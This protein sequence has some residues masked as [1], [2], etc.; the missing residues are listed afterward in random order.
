M[1]MDAVTEAEALFERSR[2]KDISTI[3][4]EYLALIK[5]HSL[6]PLLKNERQVEYFAATVHF[7]I[8]RRIPWDAHTTESFQDLFKKPGDPSLLDLARPWPLSKHYADTVWVISHPDVLS[9]AMKR[10]V[11]PPVLHRGTTLQWMCREMIPAQVMLLCGKSGGGKTLLAVSLALG[12]GRSMDRFT[13]PDGLKADAL[14][15]YCRA[16]D[17]FTGEPPSDENKRSDWALGCIV[18]Y[19]RSLVPAANRVRPLSCPGKPPIVL[20][21]DEAGGYVAAVRGLCDAL[22]RICERLTTDFFDGCPVYLVAVGTGSEGAPPASGSMPD[23]CRVV[24]VDAPVWADLEAEL[25]QQGYGPAV[26]ALREPHPTMRLADAMTTNPRAAVLLFDALPVYVD[27]LAVDRSEASPDALVDAC[28]VA[29]HAAMGGFKSKNDSLERLTLRGLRLKVM[30]AI[31]AQFRKGDLEE[32]QYKELCVDLGLLQDRAERVRT[33]DPA[34]HEK[35]PAQPRSAGEWCVVLRRAYKGRRYAVDPAVVAMLQLAMG[36][37]ETGGSGSF[38]LLVG[39]FFAAA[40]FYARHIV[41]G[42]FDQSTV[43]VPEMPAGWQLALNGPLLEL[44]GRQGVR[45]VH[46][47]RCEHRVMPYVPAT[48]VEDASPAEAQIRDIM[49]PVT[50]GA[51]TAAAVAINAAEAPFAAVM[52]VAPTLLVLCQAKSYGDA[53]LE[54]YQVYEELHKMGHRGALSRLAGMLAAARAMT[55]VEHNSVLEELQQ[56][57]GSGGSLSL[58]LPKEAFDLL[59]GD[60]DAA[61]TAAV[62]AV[63]TLEER[64]NGPNAAHA[65]LATLP[66]DEKRQVLYIVCAAGKP[67]AAVRKHPSLEDVQLLWVREG[68]TG[69]ASLYPYVVYPTLQSPATECDADTCGW[70]RCEATAA[71]KQ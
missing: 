56:L 51:P 42:G 4:N 30:E 63:P 57:V 36:H 67:P 27:M 20:V 11:K 26:R 24:R 46:K 9:A 18:D 70:H 71:S 22:F 31:A 16:V 66:S 49:H 38:D 3:K 2:G 54:E 10:Q 13:L 68:A 53:R 28:A 37:R 34:L 14:V 6:L 41:K 65:A 64:I 33:F 59:R 29:A 40:L 19:V 15:V 21:V 69:F 44:L 7:T 35:L 58:A 60:A 45:H 17:V 23:T 39:E 61:I 62:G 1:P 43:E 8:K 52:V 47:L 55:D 12:I 5:R 48:A 25:E 32:E 50:A